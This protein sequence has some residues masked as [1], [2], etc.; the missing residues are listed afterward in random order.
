M[1][2]TIY[3]S[4]KKRHIKSCGYVYVWVRIKDLHYD[5]FCYFY[6]ENKNNSLKPPS[7]SIILGMCHR[8]MNKKGLDYDIGTFIWKIFHFFTVE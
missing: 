6:S 1:I 2:H 4:L 5:R 7:N 3:E 8:L